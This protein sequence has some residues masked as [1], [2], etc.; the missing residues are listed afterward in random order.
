MNFVCRR[1]SSASNV[2]DKSDND[3][4]ISPHEELFGAKSAVPS[5][6]RHSKETTINKQKP[7]TAIGSRINDSSRNDTVVQ[8]NS[9]NKSRSEDATPDLDTCTGGVLSMKLSQQ[10]VRQQQAKVPSAGITECEP[11]SYCLITIM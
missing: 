3:I 1:N 7:G 8:N 10:R 4:S 5:M 6:N 11:V 2:S 9:P